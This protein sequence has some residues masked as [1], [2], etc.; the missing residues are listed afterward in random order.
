MQNNRYIV[1]KYISM[2]YQ[3]IRLTV[4]IQLRVA[5]FEKDGAVYLFMLPIH[6]HLC[7]TS[8]E[9]VKV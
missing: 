4:F 6:K 1:Y 2:S 9:I 3:D 5:I 8:N 7:F